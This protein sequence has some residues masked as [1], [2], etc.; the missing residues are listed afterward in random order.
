LRQQRKGLGAYLTLQSHP[1]NNLYGAKTPHALVH[2]QGPRMPWQDARLP[3]PRLGP[4]RRYVAAGYID[5][6]CRG[7][8]LVDRPGASSSRSAPL[9]ASARAA[10]EAPQ[11]EIVSTITDGWCRPVAHRGFGDPRRSVAANLCGTLRHGQVNCGYINVLYS[12]N[13]MYFPILGAVGA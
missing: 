7:V 11:G 2:S 10:S 4:A 13:R 8:R 12:E 5:A 3:P 9:T 1:K 6:G